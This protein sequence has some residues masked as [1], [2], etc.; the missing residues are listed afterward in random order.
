MQKHK[1]WIESAR[2]AIA[3]FQHVQVSN[4][5]EILQDWIKAGGLG[6]SLILTHE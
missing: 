4:L 6:N 2:V 3:V 1:S 5:F